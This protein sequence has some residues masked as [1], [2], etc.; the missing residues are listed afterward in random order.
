MPLV[1]RQ[2][3]AGLLRAREAFESGFRRSRKGNLWRQYEGLSISVFLR[4]GDGWYGWSVA[5]SEGV[6]FS[7][8][9]YE[10]EEDAMA[11]LWEQVSGW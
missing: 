8:G 5:D 11:A 7:P 2:G 6:R 10:T 1:T 3:D 4:R 9:G